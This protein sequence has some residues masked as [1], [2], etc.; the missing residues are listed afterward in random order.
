MWFPST[1]RQR[2]QSERSEEE[3]RLREQSDRL[4]KELR[5][6]AQEERERQQHTLRSGH[7][8]TQTVPSDNLDIY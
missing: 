5:E 3:A 7:E 6:S 4:L 8:Q 1:L 2:L